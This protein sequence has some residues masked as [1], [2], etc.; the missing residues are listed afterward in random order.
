M[1][2]NKKPIAI[3]CYSLKEFLTMDLSDMPDP[4][5]SHPTYDSWKAERAFE[6]RSKK[7]KVSDFS[8]RD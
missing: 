2:N 5:P 3:A 7:S 8:K 1:M 4:A 6:E